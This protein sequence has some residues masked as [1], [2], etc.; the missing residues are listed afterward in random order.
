MA[1]FVVITVIVPVGGLRG[2]SLRAG[3]GVGPVDA[4]E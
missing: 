4:V 1:L 2:L 3:A